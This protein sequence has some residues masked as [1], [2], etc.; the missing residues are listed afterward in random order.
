MEIEKGLSFS[1]AVGV[2]QLAELSLPTSEIR[3]SNPTSAIIN[4]FTN[5]SIANPEKT[6]LKKKEAGNGPLKK[7][8]SL[9][10]SSTLTKS[11]YKQ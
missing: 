6:N 10:S 4:L 5:L 2:A 11:L 3:G 1:W 9:Y 8:I 7:G